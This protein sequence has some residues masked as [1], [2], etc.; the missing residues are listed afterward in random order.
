MVPSTPLL[1]LKNIYT[2]GPNVVRSGKGGCGARSR[3]K[4][5]PE[6]ALES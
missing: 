1:R 2:R 4:R 5:N 3:D 6:G